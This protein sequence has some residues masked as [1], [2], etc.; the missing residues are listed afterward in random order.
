MHAMNS[1]SEVDIIILAWN[2]PDDTIR[3]IE[4]ALDQ[5]DVKRSVWVVDQG[6]EPE[7][8]AKLAAFCDGR[9]DVHVHWLTR[10]IGV[11]AG[12]NL[13]TRLGKA[14]F[15]VSLDNDA[16]FSDPRCVAR[17]VAT[18]REQPSLG[19]LAFRIL[20]EASGSEHMYWDY[21]EVYR[22]AGL[23]SFEVTRF[24]G[25][26]HALR[27][28]AFERAGGYDDRL[29]FG[30][31]ERDVAWRMIKLGY[32][33]RWEREL[34]V[35]HRSVTANKLTYHDRRFYFLVRNALYINH[36]FGAGAPGFARGAISFMLRGARNGLLPAAIRGIAAGCAMSLY[37]S[38]SDD[39]GK[40]NYRLTR[41]QQRYIADTDHKT[42]ES[43]LKKLRR[44][45]AALPAV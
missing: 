8:R 16:V 30:G 43:A 6:S 12:R 44:Q 7:S 28:E 26:G 41:A 17:A 31:E 27:R 1:A 25:G 11:P 24:L 19:G 35:V 3:A 34:A 9:S 22:D 45:F 39:P 13:A 29:F 37:F 36:K 18:L 40:E 20:D 15:I 21:P 42:G 32:V 4:S 10:N 23:P 2:R 5:V 14:A 33:L 38:Y